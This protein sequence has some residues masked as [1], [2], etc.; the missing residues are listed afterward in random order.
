MMSVRPR[1]SPRRCRAE[2]PGHLDCH[3]LHRM[4]QP[5]H[6]RLRNL[7]RRR[8]AA[9]FVQRNPFASRHDEVG[10]ECLGQF[11]TRKRTL[12]LYAGDPPLDRVRRSPSAL[13]AVNAPDAHVV[14]DSN[15]GLTAALRDSGASAPGARRTRMAPFGSLMQCGAFLAARQC[16]IAGQSWR[17]LGT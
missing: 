16:G 7:H 5:A 4:V 12:Q 2:A 13:V 14:G 15:A 9:P 10:T 8:K 6:G 11:R 1:R 3:V 17:C